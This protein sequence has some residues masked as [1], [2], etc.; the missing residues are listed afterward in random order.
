MSVVPNG[1]SPNSR[2]ESSCTASGVV[3]GDEVKQKLHRSRSRLA[4]FADWPTN[5][6]PV[7]S[8]KSK[9]GEV[10][11]GSPKI[12][13]K[14]RNRLNRT[15]CLQDIGEANLLEEDS[16]KAF[17][18]RPRSTEPKNALEQSKMHEL[19]LTKSVT[20]L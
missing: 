19:N 7:K 17:A 8:M 10:D 4:Q 6:M 13:S 15:E 5:T 16:F 12:T 18:V 14:A 1:P 20:R 9:L 11:L 2:C 3:S